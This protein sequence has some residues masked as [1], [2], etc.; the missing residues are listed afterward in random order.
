MA[1]LLTHSVFNSLQ[2]LV[3]KSQCCTVISH[4]DIFIVFLLPLA[5]FHTKE[6]ICNNTCLLGYDSNSAFATFCSSV[7]LRSHTLGTRPPR[8]CSVFIEK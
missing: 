6:N 5:H 8:A 2:V 1:F 7:A 4:F 3:I